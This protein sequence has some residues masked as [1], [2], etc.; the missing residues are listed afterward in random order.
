MGYDL[1]KG[2]TVIG[3][4][5][6]LLPATY[7]DSPAQ[8]TPLN[9]QATPGESVATPNSS[10]TAKR[11]DRIGIWARKV[12]PSPP[13]EPPLLVQRFGTS[14]H[15]TLCAQSWSKGHSNFGFGRRIC[16]EPVCPSSTRAALTS[17]DRQPDTMSQPTIFSSRTLQSCGASTSGLSRASRSPMWTTTRRAL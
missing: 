1:P 4:C 14:A 17:G 2:A 3:S 6:C 7:P 12:P 16:R 5:C 8:L 13:R 15:L 11:S 9:F 10:L